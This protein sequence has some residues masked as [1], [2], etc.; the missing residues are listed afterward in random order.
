VPAH[1]EADQLAAGLGHRAG[2]TGV[3]QCLHLGGGDGRVLEPGGEQRLGP[4]VRGV[5]L[6]QQPARRR[7]VGSVERADGGAAGGRHGGRP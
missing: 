7:H 6:G 3:D 2:G 1:Q 4:A 5:P